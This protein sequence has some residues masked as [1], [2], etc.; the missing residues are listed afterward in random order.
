MNKDIISCYVPLVLNGV[1]ISQGKDDKTMETTIELC[2][3]ADHLSHPSRPW[4]V[5]SN[6]M[7]VFREW[8]QGLRSSASHGPAMSDD[9]YQDMIAR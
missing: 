8:W 9:V 5:D 1:N 6:V 2:L 3:C 7:T 4:D